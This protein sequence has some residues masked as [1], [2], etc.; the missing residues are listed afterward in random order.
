MRTRAR[1]APDDTAT[2]Q[3]DKNKAPD[4]HGGETARSRAVSRRRRRER[5]PRDGGLVRGLGVAHNKV[6]A[7]SH[8]HSAHQMTRNRAGRRRERTPRGG[9]GRRSTTRWAGPR[10]RAART[11]PRSAKKG[12]ARTRRMRRLRLCTSV[13]VHPG[14][15]F[16]RVQ[17][18][19]AP[20]LVCACEHPLD[21]RQ[22]FSANA[23]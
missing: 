15:G 17:A 3:T 9:S 10:R 23:V 13:S 2:H 20:A 19:A 18:Y 7:D 21:L 5:T 11:P 4:P 6:L 16:W 12:S 8:P 1:H 22:E 14:W